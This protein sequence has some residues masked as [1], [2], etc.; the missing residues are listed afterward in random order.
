MAEQSPA[1]H[2]EA[3]PALPQQDS[4]QPQ[5]P[6]VMAPVGKDLQAALL[7]SDALTMALRLYGESDDTFAPETRE[8]MARWR[9]VVEKLLRGEA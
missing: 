2:P 9:P 1:V 5:H 6:H 8:A 3:L 4:Q 7:K